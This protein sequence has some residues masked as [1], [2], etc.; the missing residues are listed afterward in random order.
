MDQEMIYMK[1]TLSNILICLISLLSIAGGAM[2][3]ASR[4]PENMIW[5]TAGT[6]LVL[7][8]AAAMASKIISVVNERKGKK[9]V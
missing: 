8:G 3:F 9:T 7:T 4:M 5:D 1:R 6:V 2:L